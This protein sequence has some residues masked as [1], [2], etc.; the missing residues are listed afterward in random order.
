MKALTPAIFAYSPAQYNEYAS[1]KQESE[2]TLDSE[3][4]EEDEGQ[5]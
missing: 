4:E 2:E 5:S 3:T 1:V